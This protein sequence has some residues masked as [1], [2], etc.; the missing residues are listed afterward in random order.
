MVSND[1]K[2]ALE[3]IEFT[4]QKN[5]YSN[6]SKL[7]AFTTE[8]IK[9]YYEQMIFKD[10]KV[11]TV[12]SS[13]D[14]ILNAILLGSKEITCFDINIF[15]KY[16]LYLKIAA[17][18]A[19]DY[20]NFIKFFMIDDA[21]GNINKYA[22][23]FNEYLQI[24]TYLNDD[25]KYF[26]DQIYLNNNYDGYIIR[27]S[28]LFNNKHDNSN[29]KVM[30]NIYL[31]ESNYNKL[32]S[33]IDEVTITFIHSS[34]NDLSSNINNNYDVILLSNIFDHLEDLFDENYLINLKKNIV[35]NL[36][37]KINNK[38]ILALAYLYNYN[39]DK[40]VHK[41][42][43]YNIGEVQKVLKDVEVMT[44]SSVLSDDKK[45]AVIYMRR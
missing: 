14:H 45:D 18:K 19:L 12:C 23:D 6:Y 22:L 25:I 3:I 28:N 31:N 42:S 27:N 40:T 15:S 35:D 2:K 39:G 7:Y 8:N 11:L 16:Y 4:K 33:L 37:I 32:K 41:R 29:L 17:V 26:W 13:G 9:G 38:G 34:I 36:V 10:K 30:S 43:I 21:K 24:T 1:V 44:F 5:K 20:K